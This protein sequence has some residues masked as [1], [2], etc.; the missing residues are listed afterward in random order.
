MIIERKNADSIGYLMEEKLL[1]YLSS[2]IDREYLIEHRNKKE[3][4]YKELE[5]NVLNYVS[6][7]MRL[8][9]E[10]VRALEDM[11]K[12]YTEESRFYNR[13]TCRKIES[14]SPEGVAEKLYHIVSEELDQN[15]IQK[16]FVNL[17]DSVFEDIKFL[18]MS[19]A[20]ISLFE[21]KKENFIE[22]EKYDAVLERY[23]RLSEIIEFLG[24]KNNV[25]MEHLMESIPISREELD[26]TIDGTENL[27]NIRKFG[28]NTS[29]SLA[30]KGRKVQK[31]IRQK[32]KKLYSAE[33][34]ENFI[35]INSHHIMKSF[36]DPL[37]EKSDYLFVIPLSPH[38]KRK[39]S[40]EYRLIR[41]EMEF[42]KEVIDSGSTFKLWSDEVL[43]AIDINVIKE[44]RREYDERRQESDGIISGTFTGYLKVG[45]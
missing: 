20:L 19:T 32:Q 13:K 14:I 31:H 15:L 17:L 26:R 2:N 40:L 43:P 22:Q 11:E 27:F 38:R 35:Y 10:K 1:N 42:Q 36:Y 39:L 16:K 9:T 18:S 6:N 23:K 25:Q 44:D 29:I 30:P 8:T 45:R 34:V 33:E 7:D 37:S 4:F 5:E 12:V 28:Q 21:K 41:K 3:R 24:E